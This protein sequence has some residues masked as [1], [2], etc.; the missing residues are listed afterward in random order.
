ML[1]LNIYIVRRTRIKTSFLSCFLFV[2]LFSVVSLWFTEHPFHW[3]RRWE[4]SSYFAS[5]STIREEG[6]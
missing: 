2:C 4:N 6:T 3:Y 5:S 1:E